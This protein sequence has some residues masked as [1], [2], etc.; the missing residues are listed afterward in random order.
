[1]K[2]LSSIDLS[3]KALPSFIQKEVKLKRM[4]GPFS[5]SFPPVNIF[6]VNPLGLVEKR[7]TDPIEYRVITHH[8]APHGSS[9]NDGI[10]KHE[11]HISFDTL[12]YA[13]RWI[14]FIGKGA[15]LTKVDIKDAYRNL[16][17]HPLD[18]L[19]QGIVYNNQLYFDKALAF[20]S[21]SSCGIF[22]RFADVIAW[23]GFNNGIPAIIH[24]VDDFLIISP[25]NQF[26]DKNKFLQIL[27]D[28]NIPIKFSKLEGPETIIVYLGFE[29]D[30]IAMTASLPKQKKNELLAYLQKW[31]NKKSA[32]SREIRSLV[33]YLL[34]ACQVMPQARPYVQQFLNLQNQVQN[35]DR[36]INLSKELRNDIDW[37]LQAINTWNGI[38]LFEETS[39][40]DPN[41]QRFFT[42]ASNIGGGA[43]FGNYFTA[44]LWSEQLNPAI[45]DIN[46]RELIA[47]SIAVYTF[48]SLWTRKK[49]ILFTDNTC[50]MANIKRGYAS[51]DLSNM[52]IRD[53]Y[54]QQIIFSFALR[55]EYITS[56][57]NK[58]ADMLSRGQH[59]QFIKQ[60]PNSIYLTPIIPPYL[61]QFI[62]FVPSLLQ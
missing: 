1:M 20:G 29:I 59:R 15:L 33:G 51:N 47:I 23:I 13:V 17:V 46:I 50:C 12:K 7:Y 61:S 22:C 32:Q 41:I 48:K 16:P 3:A 57:D 45:I 35:I 36:Y 21:R 6:M 31:K 53:I 26:D 11:F 58:L 8:S 9:V 62:R 24:Y 2:N 30:T 19:L 5:L 40:L 52:M 27:S 60:N 10:D 34:W 56:F 18:Q 54:E 43:T 49:Y 39:W 42:D 37:W 55:V 14:R 4:I 25:P 28:L 38:Y 44:F